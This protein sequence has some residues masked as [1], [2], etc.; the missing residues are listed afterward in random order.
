M[1]QNLLKPFYHFQPRKLTPENVSSDLAHAWN[2]TVDL[3]LGQLVKFLGSG[4]W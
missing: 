1:Q 2:K 3:T 4:G